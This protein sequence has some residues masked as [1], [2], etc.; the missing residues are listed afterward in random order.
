MA[1][2][3]TISIDGV[4]VQTQTGK[5]VLEAAIEAGIYIPY[6]C[7]HSG[8]KP[9]AACRM[10][11]VAVEGGRGY[12]A[13][14]TLPVQEGMKI[15]SESHDVNELRRSVME[16]LIA[17]HPN[18]C[19]TCHRIDICGPNDIC[20]RHVS[21]NDR[22]VTCP[23]NERCEFKDT[24]R[25]L[26]ME[27]ES[28]LDY[29][30]RQIPLE[31]RDPFYDR[32]Y[33][34][35][36]TCGR[37]VR[38]CE[39]VRGDDAICFTERS[40]KALVGT[41]F[42]TSLL[43]SG[44]EFCGACIDVCPVGALVERDHK[45]EKARRVE[46]TICPH[47]PVGC[48]LNL[49]INGQG[50]VI[51]A[52][53][54]LNSPANRGQACFKGKFGLEFVNKSERLRRPLVRRNG[55]LEPATWD[56]ALDLMAARLEGYRG[57]SFALLASPNSTNEELYL[58]QKFARVVMNTNNVDQTS[59]IQPELA[60]ALE[61]SLGYAAATN[62]IWELEQAGAIL[63]F[64]SNL[65]EEQNVVGV[66][67]KRATKKGAKLVVIDPREVELT[68]YADLWLRPVP[69]TELLLL[70][71]IL[72]SILEQGLERTEWIEENCEDPATLHYALRAVEIDEVVQATNVSNDAIAE[73]A[74]LFGGPANGAVV[75]SL[76]NI[77][78]ELQRDC[79][80]ALT[81]LVLLTG[82]LGKSGAGIYP[83]RPGTNEQG[84]WDVGCVPNRLPG[85]RPWTDSSI[86]QSMETAWQCTLPT[87]RGLEVAAALLAAREKRVKAMLI[88]GDSANFTNGRL[89]DALSALPE[90]EFLVVLDTFLSPPAQLADVVLPRL[91]FAE[92][93]G[94]YTNL[95]RRIQR[96]KPAI[97]LKNSQ[98]RPE[99]WLICQLAQ[100]MNTPGFEYNSSS[101]IMDEIAR[102]CPIYAGVSCQRLEKE[103]V[104][105]FRSGVESPKPNQLLYSE[106]EYRGI[107]WPC[108]SADALSTPVLYLD[109]FPDGKA[110]T[111]TPEFRA[112]EP[113]LDSEFPA[114]LVPGRVLFQ[115][116][117]EVQ[118]EEG[119]LNRVHREQRVQIH[120]ALAE[121]LS[122][123]EGDSVEVETP[124]DRT[125]GVAR[126]DISVPPGVIAVT[127][128]FGQLAVDLQ[129]SEELDPM[130][131]VPG[132]DILPARLSKAPMPIGV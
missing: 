97:E 112:P 21:V 15:R 115:P 129:T 96:L 83:M 9:F 88:I 41:S 57:D 69:G 122:I 132:L 31:V 1:D 113:H 55:Q 13:S 14:C 82:N 7:Y 104:T 38:V 114:W 130:S 26:G 105:V 86:R 94:T 131:R 118:I 123:A 43:E 92:K 18:G 49:E 68:R 12:P 106:K 75:Y 61:R 40:G 78:Q 107:Q 29:S 62:P 33:N 56:E 10:C 124:A 98:A 19:L 24:V 63:V 85:G 77:P 34:L 67:I 50:R 79:V 90:L 89:G 32:D 30:Y 71:G 36:I 76:D 60:V 2:A 28:P 121:S 125:V 99:S 58:A 116:D 102:L 4:D 126:I 110:N 52:I 35:C 65:T 45:W 120:P 16:M 109:G 111:I 91:T 100:R 84:A 103:A 47:C 108:P 117:P 42:G 54:E 17:E 44:C 101:E 87:Q 64:N 93:D 39:E 74:R 8:M 5:M 3:I 70:G 6:L 119:K 46:R 59:N 66:P 11:V 73:A 128:L 81:D 27:L 80:L 51:R 127:T 37:C 53:P 48:Q 25:Y 23:K 20:L 72:K 22:C 95:E